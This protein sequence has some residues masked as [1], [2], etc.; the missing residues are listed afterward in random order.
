MRILTISDIFAALIENRGYKPPMPR[1]DAYDI[2]KG[3]HG[4]LEQPLVNA[5]RRVALDR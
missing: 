1:D 4:K 5:F 3:M 2:L